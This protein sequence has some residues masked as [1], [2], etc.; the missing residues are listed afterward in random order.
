[1]AWQWLIIV[2][3]LPQVPRVTLPEQGSRS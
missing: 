2:L 1:M 3:R